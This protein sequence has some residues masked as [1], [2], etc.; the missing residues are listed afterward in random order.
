MFNKKP[1]I[2]KD[3]ATKRSSGLAGVTFLKENDNEK[4]KGLYKG[5][6]LLTTKSFTK[7]ES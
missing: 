1:V 3:D 6:N 4:I 5:A 7:N 2:G